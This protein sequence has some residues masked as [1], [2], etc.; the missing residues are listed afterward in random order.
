MANV[1]IWSKVAVAVQTALGAPQAITAITKANPAVAS[2]TAHGYTAGDVLLLK[3]S[4]MRQ[5]DYRVVR[6]LAAPTADTFSLEGVD[7]TTFDTFVSGTAEE[8]TFGA[9]A[10]TFQD[11]SVS[12]GESAGVPIETIHDDDTYEIPGRRSPIL[13]S[14]GSLWDPADPALQALKGFDDIKTPGCVSLTFATGAKIYMAAYAAA[15][16]S[17]TGSSG[18]PVTTPVSLRLRGRLTTYAT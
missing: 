8:I 11:V 15:N 16:L 14:F 6:V 12:G 1:N 9:S 4:G 10:S 7:A 13:F 5:L 3:I 2:S 17:P 18:Q